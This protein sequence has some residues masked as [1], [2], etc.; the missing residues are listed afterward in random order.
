[1]TLPSSPTAN[2][3]SQL[4][5]Q[6][7]VLWLRRTADLLQAR[8]LLA[9]DVVNLLEEI[10]EIGRRE[11]RAL[12]SNLKILLLHLLKVTYQPDKQSPS[13]QASI[14]EHRQRL[15]RTLQ[16]SPSLRAYLVEVFDECYQDARELAAAETELPIACFPDQPPFAPEAALSSASL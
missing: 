4:Y 16:E 14:V 13:W 8:S 12:Y 5:E 6:D 10:E 15:R 1:M 3:L 7:Y 9:L 2:A 11:K